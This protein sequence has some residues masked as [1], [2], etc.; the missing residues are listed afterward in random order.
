MIGV[1][2]ALSNQMKSSS[3][4]RIVIILAVSV[5]RGMSKVL[6]FVV[7]RSLRILSAFIGAQPHALYCDDLAVEMR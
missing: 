4:S 5:S 2:K 7:L 6:L 1:T 3:T